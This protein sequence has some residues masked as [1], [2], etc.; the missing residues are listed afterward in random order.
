MMSR[1]RS[2]PLLHR[3]IIGP[4][5]LAR[6]YR[7]FS[8][9]FIAYAAVWIALWVWLRGR[10]G[11]IA[12]LLGG[13]AAMGAILAFA[14]DA[15]HSTLKIIAS[16]FVL[17]ALGYFAGGWFEGKLAIDHR[18]AAM[19]LWGVCYGIGFGAGLGLAFHLCQARARAILRD[20]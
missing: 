4:G 12:G 9:A 19:M 7:L 14:F 3:L 1:C 20:G 6:F 17:N 18:L 16:L 8:I 10:E 13:T 15:Q 2:G 5:S 11:E